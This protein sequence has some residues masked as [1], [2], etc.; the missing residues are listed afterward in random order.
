MNLKVYRATHK[1]FVRS[2]NEDYY[3]VRK[4]PF[5]LFIVADGVGGERGG[6]IASELASEYI[7]SILIKKV[8]ESDNPDY[9]LI[10]Q[11]AFKETNLYVRYASTKDRRT[12]GMCTTLTLGFI[13]QETLYVGHV[14][15]SGAY[16]FRNGEEI[17]LT[18]PHTVAYGM[19][20]ESDNHPLSHVLTRVVG[21]KDPLEVDINVTKLQKGDLILMATDG[22]FKYSSLNEIKTVLTNSSIKDSAKNLV[23]YGLSR[24]GIDNI[25]VVVCT[26]D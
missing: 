5:P 19:G 16:I 6:E 26:Y 12:Y 3:F 20:I 8:Q 17:N 7:A 15:D 18:R 11:E 2:K 22:L 23:K 25:S 24:G 21:Q 13:I 10:I 14:G 4:R 9:S 1:G